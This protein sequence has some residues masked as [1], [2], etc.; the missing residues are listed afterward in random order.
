[1]ACA[2]SA[3][4]LAPEDRSLP[5][6]LAPSL[7]AALLRL[8]RVETMGSAAKRALR[9]LAGFVGALKIK[10]DD[11][12]VSVG[13]P[14]EPGVADSGDLEVDLAD[15][16]ATVAEGAREHRTAVVLFIDELQY[17]RENELAAL[18]TAPHRSEQRRLRSRWLRLVCR[19]SWVEPAARSLT[20]SG[21][22]SSRRSA[23]WM[24]RQQRRL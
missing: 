17:V 16:L 24:P 12:E 18:I 6:L 7:R 21:C 5:G 9:A 11:I 22:S 3:R 15:L 23:D 13:L 2:A 1:M 19:S 14:L 4:P 8:D 10:Y 20:R